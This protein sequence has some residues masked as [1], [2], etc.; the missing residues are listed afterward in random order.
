MFQSLTQKYGAKI[1]ISRSRHLI[2]I[3][4]NFADCLEIYKLIYVTVNNISCEYVDLPPKD[5]LSILAR[6]VLSDQNSIDQLCNLTA[7]LITPIRSGHKETTPSRVRNAEDENIW[8]LTNGELAADL[9]SGTGDYWARRCPETALP[10][11]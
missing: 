10:N 9:L 8:P 1:D 11:Y 3:T 7:T 4:A 6:N 2:R 5:R